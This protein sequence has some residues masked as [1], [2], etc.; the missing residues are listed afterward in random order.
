MKNLAFILLFSFLMIGCKDN[1]NAQEAKTKSSNDITHPSKV[2]NHKF[3][4]QKSETEWKEELTAQQFHI[5]REAGTERPNS[6]DLLHI[7][8]KGVF[9]CAACGNP[10][11]R[12]KN[13]FVSGTGW[14]S[15]DQPIKGGV[16]LATDTKLGY[17]RNEV[18]CAR[19]GGH[20]GH[21]FNDGPEKT[22]GLRYCMD[23]AAMKFN[24]ADK[25]KPEKE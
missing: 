14:P 1:G 10:V 2:K 9:V 24:P 8:G 13:Q 17:K 19:C 3:P 18:L 12:N 6:S 16:V 23:G 25:N 11:Y 22:T 15:F 7:K 5:L 20:L 4:V 21:L